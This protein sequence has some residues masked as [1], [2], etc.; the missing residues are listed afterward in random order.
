MRKHLLIITLLL[1]ALSLNG[2]VQGLLNHPLDTTTPVEVRETG[3]FVFKGQTYHLDARHFLLD[4]TLPDDV[5]KA[6]PFLFND[7]KTAVGQLADGT[8]EEPMVLYIAPYVYWVDDPDDPRVAVGEN[9]REPFGMTVRCQ[10]LHLVGLAE[11]PR[12]VVL[13]SQRGQTQ[14]AVG[15]FTM[16]DFHGDGLMVSH[17]TMGNFCNVDLEYPLLPSLGRK[18]RSATIT[19]AHVA[20]CHGDRVVARDVRF[21]SR[22]NMNPL[23][24]AKRIL[25]DR[26]HM[27]CTDDAL[28]GN[29]VY[30]HCDFDFYGQKPFYTTHPAGA[31]MLDCDFHL[32]GASGNAYFCK[33]PGPLT[34]I[35][36]RFHSETPVKVGWT[37]YPTPWMRCYQSNVTFN[38]QPLFVGE[39]H[40]ENTVDISHL[41]LLGVYKS[42][43]GYHV[44]E[45]LAG[46]DGWCPMG[47]GQVGEAF[48]KSKNTTLSITP[49]ESESH[50]MESPVVL[51]VNAF[52]HGGYAGKE[53][54]KVEWKVLED[55]K[56]S[57]R[58]EDNGDGTCSV[59][60]IYDGDTPLPVTVM[61]VT[62]EGLQAAAKVTLH[63]VPLLPPFLI[64]KPRITMKDGLATLHYYLPDD[65]HGDFSDVTWYVADDKKGKGAIPV[66]VTTG[67]PLCEYRLKGGEAGKVL[68]ARVRLRQARS[69]YGDPIDVVYG[70][71]GKKQVVM[72]RRLE[73]DFH[74]FPCQW[75]P[76]V[77]EGFWTVDGFKPADTEEFPW[78]FNP[79]RPMW[80]YG[81]GFNGAVGKGLL[82]A[83]RGARMMFTPIERTYGDMEVALDVDPTKTAGQGFGSATG[84]Y[85]D[86]CIKFDNRT[87][88]GYALRIIRTTKYSKAV[89]FQLIRYDN[90]VTTPIGEPVSATCYRTGCHINI[91]CSGNVLSARVVTDTQLPV[92]ED[93]ALKTEV[94]LSATVTPNNFGGFCLQHTGSCGE[95]TTILHH[96]VIEWGQNAGF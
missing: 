92:P 34:L 43:E 7:F 51:R 39:E 91:K 15:N 63:A 18:K 41:P 16:L 40:P 30:L 1:M 79:S 72:E 36:C 68:M 67:K 62:E 53:V 2:Q 54:G 52:R 23:N 13:A 74:D 81:E 38:G 31:V 73:T 84:Q 75:Q 61:A 27:E 17:L 49:R 83:Q 96:L 25:F 21:V 42:D 89:D 6:A 69:G 76:L 59:V 95:S 94:N 24:G 77:K 37:P 35:D 5:V 66:A 55:V 33:A 20:Y 85:M 45:L 93:P 87:L 58:L 32:H 65:T 44:D 46:D 12:D 4:A 78:S 14:G 22:L 19:Q 50:A 56:E 48:G 64:E 88:T 90:G 3:R 26:C 9:G 70:K 80:E 86:V 29:G 60:S 10:N 71:V 82:Q 47:E 11:D 57:V 28:T 8:E